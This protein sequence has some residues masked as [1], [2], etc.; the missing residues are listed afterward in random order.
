L[1]MLRWAALAAALAAGAT[2]PAG[3]AA[4]AGGQHVDGVAAVVNDDVILQSDVEEQLYLLLARAQQQ[5]DSDMVDTLRRQVL[6]Q[7][8]DDKLIVVEA[9]KQGMTVSDVEVNRVVEQQLAQKVQELG[10]EQAFRDQLRR[11][12]TTEDKLREK[13]HKDIRLQMLGQ[14]LLAKQFPPRAVPQAEAEAFFKANPGRFPKAPAEARL[15]VIQIPVVPDSVASAK[16]RAAVL[17]ARKRIEA[18]EKFAKVA[19]DVSDDPNSARSGGD[20]GFFTQGT[21]EPAIEKAS[22]SLKLNKLSDPVPSPYGWHILEVLERDTLKTRAGR[23][24]LGRDD[25]P[26]LEAHVRHILVRVPIT[27]D[28]AKRAK[29]LADR[30]RGEAVKGTDFATL[31]R[32]YSKYQGAQS[33]DGDVGFVSMA[34]LQPS[35]RSGIDSLEVGQVS[36][37]LTNQAG[38]N[39][40]KV[41]DRK[42]EHAYT[43]DEI[44]SE[45]PDA[46]AQ[47]Q[48][49]DKYDAWMKGLRTKAS[50]E[51]R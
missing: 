30:V 13:Y 27:D 8:I 42:A 28:D 22:F 5:P 3:A 51:Y 6:D 46:V 14:R 4:P 49:K 24:S 26:L 11:E 7:L 16:G 34:S 39:I 43:L 2:A 40:F 9:Q 33:P 19:A 12:N 47:I 41:T 15:S 50:I 1:K 32:R 23:D 25:K 29:K 37:V 45:L 31:V 18:G 35:I 48:F 21:M 44:K 17:A 38:Y 20:L 10:G 36:E